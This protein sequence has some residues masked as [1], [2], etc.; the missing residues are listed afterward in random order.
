[1]KLVPDHVHELRESG[2]ET[3][4]PKAFGPRM[5]NASQPRSIE[6]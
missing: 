1:M 4:G 5:S 3:S 6:S 2:V